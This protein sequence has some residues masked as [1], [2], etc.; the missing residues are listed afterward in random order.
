MAVPRAHAQRASKSDPR[1][2]SMGDALMASRHA[3]PH[4]HGTLSV[5]PIEHK[6]VLAT[7]LVELLGPQPGQVAV[8]CTFGAGGHARRRLA[9]RPRRDLICID[10]DPVAEQRFESFSDEVTCKTRFIGADFAE[11]LRGLRRRRRPSRHDLHGPR[12]VLDAGRCLGARLLLLIRRAA[13]HAHGLP[14]GV[15]R[16]RPGQRVARVADRPGPAPF[17]RGALRRRD[18]AR[19]RQA[20][21]AEHD[22]RSSSTR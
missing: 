22:L 6:P 19:D 17:R 8:D 4:Q 20:P 21:P 7:E 9:A 1:E 2:R 11:G 10:R 12:N 14:P 18:R 16:R 15:Q 5:M 13:R 3:P